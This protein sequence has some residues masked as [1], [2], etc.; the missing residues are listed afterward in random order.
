MLHQGMAIHHLIMD[1]LGF[2]EPYLE[3]HLLHQEVTLCNM[4]E[5]QILM[6][7]SPHK[8]LCIIQVWNVLPKTQQKQEL[9]HSSRALIVHL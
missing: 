9:H 5:G 1:L 6:P 8:V 4:L 7:S 2:L 3:R